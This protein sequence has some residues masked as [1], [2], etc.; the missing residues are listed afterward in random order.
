MMGVYWTLPCQEEVNE[1][2][3]KMTKILQK[4][5]DGTNGGF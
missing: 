4:V 2:L 1:V 5:W 3:K